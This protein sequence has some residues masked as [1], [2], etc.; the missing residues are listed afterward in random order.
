M[1][2]FATSHPL[3]RRRAALRALA[4]SATALVTGHGPA[5]ASAPQTPDPVR[6]GRPLV[7]PRDH[8]AHPASRI[9]WWYITGWLL[10]APPSNPPARHHPSGGPAV[11]ESPTLAPAASPDP[12]APGLIGFQVTF[13]RSRTGLAD[14]LAG[15][16]A[17]RHILFA[18]AAVSEIGPQ[19]HRHAE[20]IGQG[21]DLGRHT[22][23]RTP[24][25][26]ALSPP[27]A[28]CPWR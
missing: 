28:P 6:R 10:P 14:A 8:G 11:A 22:A 23:A 17:P 13:F 24:N 4:A 18:H 15:R 25:G 19:R 9:E 21:H 27:F 7:F 3:G 16:F 5:A 26:L 12:G 20:R 1:T 2:G